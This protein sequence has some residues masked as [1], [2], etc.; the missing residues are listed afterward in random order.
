MLLRRNKA[1]YVLTGVYEKNRGQKE[2][3]RERK[4]EKKEKGKEK[5]QGVPC[6]QYDD[7]RR[8]PGGFH[9]TVKNS[10]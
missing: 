6:K 4:Q 7:F 3:E 1:D 8:F 5:V 2:K 9:S 10:L